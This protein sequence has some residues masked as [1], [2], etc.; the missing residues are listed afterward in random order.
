MVGG[1]RSPDNCTIQ[2]LS[3]RFSRKSD[4]DRS[5]VEGTI[6]REWRLFRFS[7]RRVIGLTAAA[8]AEGGGGRPPSRA[9]AESA[10]SRGRL[11][12]SQ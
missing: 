3:A 9:A 4:R 5:Q 7:A 8:T 12:C 10:E 6:R 1:R 11:A 2:S